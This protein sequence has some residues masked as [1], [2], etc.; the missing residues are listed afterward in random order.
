MSKINKVILIILDSLGIGALPDADE[1][2]DIGSNTLLH[3]AEYMDGLELNYMEKLGLGKIENIPGL[4]SKLVAE[5]CYGKMN[6]ASKGKDTTTGHWELAGL[7]LEKPFPTYP[8]GF[9]DEVIEPFKK[10]IRREIIGNRPAST[11]KII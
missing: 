8:D 3:I 1:Y 4:N 2:D 7:I 11:T 6:E 5:G 10:S 9:P